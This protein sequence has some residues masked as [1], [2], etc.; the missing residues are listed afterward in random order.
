MDERYTLSPFEKIVRL[1]QFGASLLGSIGEAQSPPQRAK[2][3][4]LPKA[5]PSSGPFAP[6]VSPQ[7]VAAASGPFKGAIT[8]L[9]G[10]DRDII[11]VSVE[12]KTPNS[13]PSSPPATF[14]ER[15]GGMP[16]PK[17]MG[18]DQIHM[19]QGTIQRPQRDYTPRE[20]LEEL[21]AEMDLR[22]QGK[23]EEFPEGHELEDY[24]NQLENRNM[25]K[26]VDAYAPVLPPIEQTLPFKQV[27]RLGVTEPLNLT[28][29]LTAQ[30]DPEEPAA[31]P[32]AS[33]TMGMFRNFWRDYIHGGMNGGEQVAM[34]DPRDPNNKGR[35]IV[36]E[37][38]GG[39]VV[40]FPSKPQTKEGWGSEG[41]NH[42]NTQMRSRGNPLGVG[43][44]VRGGGTVKDNVT[45]YRRFLEKKFP[46]KDK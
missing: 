4:A 39:G 3:A 35:R 43:E 34:M 30:P 5:R 42:Y 31:G 19:P 21:D 38:G 24:W 41:M 33:G 29:F 11:S 10:P 14:D 45:T 27:L 36:G 15:F 37:G 40:P 23:L 13:K 32:G 12:D 16:S 18:P 25:T 22:D 20:Q 1:A 2:V 44:V 17:N 8:N 9:T 46:L 7:P 28:S 26:Q 6:A